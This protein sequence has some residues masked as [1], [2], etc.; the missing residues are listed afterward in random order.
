MHPDEMDDMYDDDAEQINDDL[1]R[2][3][4]MTELG[5]NSDAESVYDDAENDDDD[6]ASS[7]QQNVATAK[8]NESKELIA[9]TAETLLAKWN[10]DMDHAQRLLGA[11]QFLRVACV[12]LKKL[13]RKSESHL[14]EARRARAQAGAQAFRHARVIGATVVGA[15]RRLEAIRAAEPFAVVVEEAC[16]VIEPT[17]MSVLAVNTLRKLEMIGDHRQLPAFVQQCWFN[18]ETTMPSI[19]TSLFERLVS[20]VVRTN[21][22]RDNN[23]NKIT[24]KCRS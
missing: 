18:F 20:G 9:E 17:L 4:E 23:N 13:K 3:Q 24:S 8:T 12:T 21:S 7:D 1:R 2:L 19:K 10:W 16:E 6:Q 5:A 15:S 14:E 22:H 11:A